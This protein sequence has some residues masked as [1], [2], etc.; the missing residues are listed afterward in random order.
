MATSVLVAVGGASFEAELLDALDKPSFQVVRRCVDVPDLLTAADLQTAQ[1]AVVSA[2]LRSLDR[3]VVARLHDDGVTVVGATAET[4]SADE[5]ALRRL[6]V[7]LFVSPDDV[8][9]L[10]E[11]LES[12]ASGS[13]GQDQSTYDDTAAEPPAL[14]APTVVGRLIAVWGGAGAPGRSVVAMGLSAELARR[15]LDTILV[16]ADVYGGASAALLG[17]IDESSGLLAAARAANVGTLDLP[18]LAH[19]ARTVSPHLRVLT[20]LPR[21]DRWTE[22][23]PALIREVLAT[24][25]ALAAFTVVDCGFSLETDEEISYDVGAPRRNG[26]TLEVLQ[27]AD[28]VVVVGAADP[29]GLGRLIRALHELSTAVP[30]VTAH[31]V[32]NRVRDTLGWSEADITATVTRATGLDGIST[33]P[34]DR[35]ACDKAMVHGRTLSEAAPDARLTRSLGALAAQLAGLP[36]SARR[37][38]ASRFVRR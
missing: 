7:Q 4:S 30:A 29:L 14:N 25:R 15:R 24:C 34:E 10:A 17:L 18:T 26:A 33:L 2:H 13:A 19:H 1:V 28:L 31:V 35:H 22:L 23:K 36:D 32:I 12:A 3:S 6:G 27:E 37:R 16:D 5:A 38:G 9:T 11:I 20:G 21:A 8:A